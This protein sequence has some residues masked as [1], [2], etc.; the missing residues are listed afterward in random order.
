MIELGRAEG[1]V[2]FTADVMAGNLGMMLVFQQ[3]GLPVQSR[4]ETGGYQISMRLLETDALSSPKG[5][6]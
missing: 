4:F 6:A 3:S 2:G 5:V 1:V